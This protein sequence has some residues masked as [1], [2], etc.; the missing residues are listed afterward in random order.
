MCPYREVFVP[1]L[2]DLSTCER[3][4]YV[5]VHFPWEKLHAT[6][7]ERGGWGCGWRGGVGGGGAGAG[8][9]HKMR[10]KR[11]ESEKRERGR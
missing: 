10:D 4:D 8:G 6:E 9:K 7:T 5:S 3:V 1:F 11:E 2:A